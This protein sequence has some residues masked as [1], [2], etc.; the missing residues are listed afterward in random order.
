MCL[1]NVR[2]PPSRARRCWW[3]TALSGNDLMPV[4]DEARERLLRRADFRD[5]RESAREPKRDVDRS[6]DRA[7]CRFGRARR[8]RADLGCGSCS[9]RLRGW[10]MRSRAPRSSSRRRQAEVRSRSGILLAAASIPASVLSGQ[11]GAHRQSGPVGLVGDSG[12]IACAGGVVRAVAAQPLAGVPRASA[13]ARTSGERT[14]GC[15]GGSDRSVDDFPEGVLAAD[16]VAGE[17]K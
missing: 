7:R 17:L 16:L 1:R 14:A 15:L 8:P 13:P 3:A 2:R 5:R 10:P 9:R 12:L 6:I 11:G 4:W